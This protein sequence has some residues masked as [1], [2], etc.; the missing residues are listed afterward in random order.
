[1]FHVFASV[2]CD[3]KSAFLTI[4]LL[5]DHF[6]LVFHMHISVRMTG[7]GPLAINNLTNISSVNAY[8]K[9][10]VIGS[11]IDFPLPVRQEGGVDEH[12]TALCWFGRM[13]V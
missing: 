3:L 1:M 10:H 12:V 2:A 5:E 7:D 6:C 8:I 11:T 13:G 4:H 9:V